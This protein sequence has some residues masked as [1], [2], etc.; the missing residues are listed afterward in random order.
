MLWRDFHW[1]HMAS[2]VQRA[3]AQCVSCAQTGGRHRDKRRF[4]LF[5]ASGLLETVAMAL[6]VLLPNT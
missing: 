2:D 1:P 6:L 3:V 5:P 4:Q